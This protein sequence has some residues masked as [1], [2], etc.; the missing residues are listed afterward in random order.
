MTSAC[1]CSN[2]TLSRC[3]LNNILKNASCK[4]ET[5]FS[6][7]RRLVL[8]LMFRRQSCWP[9]KCSKYIDSC[10]SQK[11]FLC[12][13]NDR[14]T[15]FFS[16]ASF[17]FTEAPRCY[18][19]SGVFFLL[20]YVWLRCQQ[21]MQLDLLQDAK[22]EALRFPTEWR[23]R[24]HSLAVLNAKKLSYRKSEDAILHRSLYKIMLYISRKWETTG[25]LK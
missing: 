5:P 6:L 14:R 15:R 24:D 2:S 10:S 16:L 12:E 23:K 21:S 13:A 19:A 11:H 22:K 4:D 20:V 9:P 25:I 18:S 3:L 17:F 7:L 1:F 8:R